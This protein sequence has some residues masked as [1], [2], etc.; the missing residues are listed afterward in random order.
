MKY[1][2]E[3]LITSFKELSFSSIEGTSLVLFGPSLCHTTV[4][5]KGTLSPLVLR[6]GERTKTGLGSSHKQQQTLS[7]STVPQVTY[8]ASA[9]IVSC[10]FCGF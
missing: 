2:Q 5:E 1:L 7:T 3:I 8:D 9:G 6:D 10:E 4:P